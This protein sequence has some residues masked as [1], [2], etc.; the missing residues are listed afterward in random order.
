ME[1]GRERTAA[2]PLLVELLQACP[3][4]ALLVTSRTALR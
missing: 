2:A 1:G 4:L 3:H